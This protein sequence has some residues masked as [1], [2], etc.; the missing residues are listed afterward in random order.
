M[1]IRESES[2]EWIMIRVLLDSGD[3]DSFIND[4]LSIYYQLPYLI[5]SYPIFLILI[6]DHPSKNDNINHYISLIFYIID[7]KEEI[8]LD[9]IS[10]I[11]YIILGIF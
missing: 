9:I 1:D 10:I 11:H 7:Y 5:K 3:Q 8:N 2:K 4:N 6:D